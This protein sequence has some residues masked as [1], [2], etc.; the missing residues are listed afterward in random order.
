LAAQRV[1]VRRFDGQHDRKLG[2]RQFRITGGDRCLSGCLRVCHD[3]PGRSEQL[4]TGCERRFVL[5]DGPRQVVRE[6]RIVS[7]AQPGLIGLPSRCT[8][9][10]RRTGVQLFLL[11]EQ[12]ES[13]ILGF[14]AQRLPLLGRQPRRCRRGHG[15]RGH[16]VLLDCFDQPGLF[17]AIRQI[18]KN[19]CQHREQHDARNTDQCSANAKRLCR[20]GGRCANGLRAP[21]RDDGRFVS[22]LFWPGFA[23]G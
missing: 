2:H 22:I 6:Q 20:F 19:E 16:G 21:Y 13:K 8:P 3:R 11:F 5:L 17:D 1:P 12:R 7:A 9:T 18:H 15:F 23:H 14:G 10:L 4:L